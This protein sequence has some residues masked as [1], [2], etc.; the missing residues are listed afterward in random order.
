MKAFNDLA[1]YSNDEIN[2][3]IALADRLDRQPEPEALK[4]KVLSLLFLSPSLRTL[5]SF[6]A[7]MVRLGGSAVHDDTGTA[8]DSVYRHLGGDDE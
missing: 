6:Q 3:L 2:A 7:A 4:G 5:A 1:D 8:F